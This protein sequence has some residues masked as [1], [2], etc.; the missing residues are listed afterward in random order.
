[1]PKECLGL[2]VEKGTTGEAS[3][4]SSGLVVHR[5]GINSSGCENS[6]LSVTDKHTIYRHVIDRIYLDTS[7]MRVSARWCLLE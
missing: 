6:R 5:S 4:V 3:L 1:M 2:P 7:C